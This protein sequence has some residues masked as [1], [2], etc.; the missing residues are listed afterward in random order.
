MFEFLR[1]LSDHDLLHTL[2]WLGLR[3]NV[4]NAYS[5]AA[6]HR[7]LA[8]N[9]GAEDAEEPPVQAAI[10]QV[11]EEIEAA[12]GKPIHALTQVQV[13]PYLDRMCEIE[14]ERK[15]P[16]DPEVTARALRIWRRCGATTATSVATRSPDPLQSIGTSRPG[17][18]RRRPGRVSLERARPTPAPAPAPGRR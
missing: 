12:E 9:P 16:A 13:G 3:L 4:R 8:N 2:Y 10:A 7:A 15:E 18:L 17:R 5:D 14:E 1:G 11:L 6:Y